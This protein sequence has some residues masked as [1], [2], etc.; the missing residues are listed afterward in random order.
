MR[1]R[2]FG[3]AIFICGTRMYS[4]SMNRAEA[5]R[6]ISEFPHDNPAKAFK[7]GIELIRQ[8]YPELL[9]PRARETARRYPRDP[10][11]HQLLGLAARNSG[12]SRIAFRAFAKAA[13]L[14]PS[15]PL[16]AHSAAR[17]A[18]EAGRPA[19]YLFDAAARLA[20]QNGE[21]LQGRAA[22][23]VAENRAS[24][25][26]ESLTSAL[27]ANPGWLE[28]HRSL[29]H[30]RGQLGLPATEAL[31]YSLLAHPRA[32]PLHHLRILTL[33]EA[34]DPDAAIRALQE[35]R[36]A[37]G[38][39][40]WISL[41]EAHA[42]SE[43][44]RASEADT[45]FAGLPMPSTPGDASLHAR[46]LLRNER[47][48]AARDLVEPLLA[49]DTERVLLPY[50]ALAWRLTD[51]PKADWLEG[52][53]SLVKVIDLYDCLPDLADLAKHLR[54]RHFASAA[55]LDQSVEGGTQ[56][57]GN[58][59][60]RDEPIIN[61][62]RKAL[63]DAVDQ[64]ICDLAPP[65]DRHPTLIE[66]RDPRRIA[67]SWSVR[68]AENG[69]HRDHV[70]SQG[71]ISSALYVA[72]PD[73][74]DQGAQAGWLTLGAEHDLLPALPPRQVVEPRPGRLVLFPSTMWHGTR[75]FSEG[76]RLTV[77]FDIARPRQT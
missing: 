20:P 8:D 72:L 7:A 58:L 66:M 70:H 38:N 27:R 43:A 55:P 2:A 12:E 76:E 30:L 48:D 47:G 5:N 3:S 17:T 21:I 52:E 65:I 53:Q 4:T 22:A 39:K 36:A 73:L 40:G 16:I 35:A 14:A 60:L 69:F 24:E 31:E 29:A 74:E 71:W 37:I 9:L 75:P 56:T 33:L 32:E 45:L 15:D 46:W 44:G 67:G 6:A 26:L 64:Y 10:K 11:I 1:W 23:L 59:L 54:A 49:S 77:A 57:D 34:S 13:T 18:L 42:V 25:A 62:L 63:L 28:G 51:D 61:E 68:L 41:Y 50:A 19:V